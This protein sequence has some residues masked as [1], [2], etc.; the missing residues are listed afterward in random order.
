[1]KNKIIFTILSISLLFAWSCTDLEEQVLDESFTGSGQAESISGAIA[2]AYGQIA[3]TWRHVNYFG[4]QLIS[5][6]E[7]ILPYRGGTDWYDGGKFL[8]THSHTIT[9]TND[10]VTSSWK[11][12]TKNISRTLSA[13]EVLKPLSDEGNLE[14]TEALYEMKALRAYL[15]ILTL[16]SWGVVFKKEASTEVSEIL[17]GQDAINYIENELLSVV[18]VINTTN[19]SG[20][21]TQSAVW[22]FLARLNLN[23]PVYRDPYGT[24]DFTT[25]DLD[26]VI[27]YTDKIINSGKFNLSPEYFDLFNDDNHSN[28]E[29]IFA[30]DQR[31]V[32]KNEH[33]RWTYWS[34]AGSLYGRPEF[35]S[36]DGTDG[37][38]I[39]PDFYQTWVDAYQGVDPADADARFYAENQKIPEDLKD[40]TGITPENDED[41]YY[42]TTA[43]DYE[44]DRGIIRGVIWGPRKDD[45]GAF[46][47]CDN[48]YR[49]YPVIQ[50]KG[51]GPDK[52]VAYVNH[53]LQV[54]F[55][56]EGRLHNKGY[57]VSKYQFSHTSPNANNYSSIDLVLLRYAEI[58]MMRAE[59]K[60]RKG[61]NAGALADVNFVRT[62]RTARS[63]I[64][65]ALTSMDLDI[66]YRELGFEFYWE[67]LRRSN[68]IRFGHYEDS[69]TE[70]TDA[71][72]NH[73]LFPI[74]QSAIDGASNTQ[75]YLD[76]NK[77]Y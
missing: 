46:Y 26:N 21:I 62:S 17:R 2:P 54:D 19:G 60:L 33:S 36:S 45:T 67:G 13:I 75:G 22:G 74:P 51:N 64:P 53:V 12:L 77:G 50:R 18:D 44:F 40:L 38:A 16:D 14:A 11:E 56:N 20:R 39:T 10:L 71:D 68:Q 37:P 59:A 31:G 32:L 49:I 25:Q 3:W 43:E 42:C 6:D 29:I 47:T 63:P 9:P 27:D 28:S 57:R 24:P 61:D 73:R 65:I 70:K 4:L 55:T 7:G 34:L 72:V 5:A 76:Q 58:Y 52:D 8:A 15:S 23:A 1:M 69:W 66:L 41:H 30:I 35:T 48:G